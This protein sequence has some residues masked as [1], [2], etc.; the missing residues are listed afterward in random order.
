M[1]WSMAQSRIVRPA[2]SCSG[3]GNTTKAVGAAFVVF[4]L[5]LHAPGRHAMTR[6]R[7]SVQALPHYVRR[8]I[9]PSERMRVK[10]SGDIINTNK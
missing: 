8:R 10:L 6:T 1:A 9:C 3:F 2:Q 5:G 7:K 4:L